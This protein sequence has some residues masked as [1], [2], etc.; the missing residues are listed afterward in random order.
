MDEKFSQEE[1]TAVASVLFGLADADFQSHPAEKECLE[2]CLEE[3]GLEVAG[4]SPIP[5]NE[6]PKLAYGTLKGMTKEKK[7]SFSLMMTRLSRSDSHFGPRE[8][9]FVKEVLD[10]CDVPFVHR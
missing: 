6:L 10:Y 3:L 2:A 4:F 1:K 8:Q 7:R 9:A 5:E